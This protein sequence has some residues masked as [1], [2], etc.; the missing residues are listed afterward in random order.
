VT[1]SP[2]LLDQLPTPCLV[3]DALAA[4]R[5]IERAASLFQ[6]TTV[7]LRP[8]FKAHKCTRL[9]QEQLKAGGC[10][11]V[12]CQT[13]WE[14]ALLAERGF[15]DIL[16]ANQIVD[17]HAVTALAEAAAKARVTVAVDSPVHVEILR[18]ACREHAV[19]MGVVIELDVGI[20]RCGLPAGSPALVPL[21]RSIGEAAGLEF[22][23]LQAYEGH[24]VLKEDRALRRTMVWQ[25]A[26]QARS[27][28]G[29]LAAAGIDCE[30]VSGGGTGTYDLA[31]ESGVLTEVQAGSYVLMDA[32]YATLDLPFEPAL[33]CA[34]TLISKRGPDAGVL[35]AGLK[36][37]T[38][39]YGMPR[40][41]APGLS[42]IALS[43]EHA[44]VA[45]DPS[46]PFT[47]GQKVLLV[48]AHI[49]PA[50]NLHDALIVWDGKT[51][52]PWPV[53]GRRSVTMTA[54]HPASQ[55]SRE[56]GGAQ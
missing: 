3:V 43:D 6:G 51:F 44:R 35:N 9:L 20:G 18:E 34:T 15:P 2:E 28:L 39:E 12:T 4:R 17:R 11:G 38:V 50:V 19:T 40:S 22:R 32:R 8:H 48:P 14:A 31:A 46:I 29:R 30:I 54:L 10:A 56:N 52:E 47:I 33:F 23:G 25:A 16:V 5:N 7:R 24:A 26:A 45:L 49:D 42:V 36:E 53:D 13:A 55:G 41:L 27:E 37:L 1:L 21:A